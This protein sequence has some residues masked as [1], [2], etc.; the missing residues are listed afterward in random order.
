MKK[1]FLFASIA[2]FALSSC[3][4]DK[5]ENNDGIY[6][7]PVKQF[8][9]G[10][11]WTWI[12]VDNND[13]PIRIGIAIDNDAMTSLDPGGD[14]TGGHTH[15]NG[16]SLAFHPKANITPF[17]HALLDWN[18]N[19]HEPAGVYDLPHFDFH[20]YMTSEAERLAIPPFEVDNTGFLN[21]PAQGYLPTV[22]PHLYVP[23]PGGV[24]QMG[25]HW[26]DVST[27]ELNGQTFTQTFLYG[28][29]NGN[30]TFFEPMITKAFLDNNA[31]F[32][33]SIPVADKFK[34]AGYYPTQMRVEKIN[35]VTNII[36][37][38]FVYRQAS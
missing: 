33:R 15:T 9:H 38:G 37:E 22:M 12:Q 14:H 24:P 29:Y 2:I 16:V 26:I 25:T 23:V 21:F 1:I 6:K 27:P 13:K 35:G 5:N 20:F 34:T 10:K 8:Q 30:V 28:T 36:L 11:A 3:T 7:G 4:K 17:K 32:Q 18:P 31:S 19:G